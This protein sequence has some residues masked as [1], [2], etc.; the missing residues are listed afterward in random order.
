MMKTDITGKPERKLFWIPILMTGAQ[1]PVK[2]MCRRRGKTPLTAP[3]IGLIQRRK[4]QQLCKLRKN[5]HLLRRF[6]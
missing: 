1:I 2:Q 6:L 5:L 3:E 4:K